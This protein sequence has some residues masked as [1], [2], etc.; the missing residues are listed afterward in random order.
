MKAVW[1]KLQRRRMTNR[2]WLKSRW[3]SGQAPGEASD[4]GASTFG[5]RPGRGSN[6]SHGG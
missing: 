4:P 6:S 1:F 3:Q 2:G 5:R